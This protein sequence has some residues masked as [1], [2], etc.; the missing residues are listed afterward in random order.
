MSNE[1]E[2]LIGLTGHPSSGKDT[3]AA[4]LVERH[5]FVMITLSD[6]IRFYISEHGMGEATRDLLRTTAVMLREEHGADYLM[7]MALEHEAPRLIISGVR[8]VG[9]AENLKQSGGVI[10]SCTAP[11]EVRYKRAI[12]RG[13]SKDNISFEDFVRQE[14]VEKTST[15]P[16]AQ[17]LNGVIAMADYTINNDGSLNDLEEKIESLLKNLIK[18]AN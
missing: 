10:V 8:T 6:M 1:R 18:T 14:D 4:Y 13:S 12:G 2:I 17:N 11:L 7:R 15:N 3:V 16:E 5:G 9:E